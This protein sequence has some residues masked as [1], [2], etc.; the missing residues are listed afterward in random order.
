MRDLA[1][2][3]KPASSLCNLRCSYCFYETVAE[4][5]SV[6]SRG[7][8]TA[9]TAQRI[10]ANIFCDLDSGDHI[11]FAFQ[12]GEP[13]LAG[14]GFF[15][16]F[17][18]R[19]QQINPGCE[20]SY[21]LQTNGIL[22]DDSWCEFLKK[23]DF[24]VGLSL[25][26]LQPVHDGNRKDG[27]GQGTFARVMKAKEYLE[28]WQ[29]DYN[30]LATLTR[31]LAAQP[32]KVWEFIWRNKIRF[33]QFTPCFGDMPGAICPEDF[34]H[35]YGR[36]IP[37]WYNAWEKGV[38]I[39]VKLIDDLVTLLATGRITACGLTGNCA[40]QIIV[41]ADGSVYPCDFFATDSWEIG[42]LCHHSIKEIYEAPRQTQFR[43][44][45]RQ[46][47]L[48]ENCRYKA[49]CGGNCP[50]MQRHICYGKDDS[51]CGMQQLLDRQIKILLSVARQLR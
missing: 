4:N 35:F 12:G 42:N 41:E 47:P 23:Y 10:L 45:K 6:Y 38:Y 2:M 17:V 1:I 40:P 9:D 24:L 39:S 3:L 13:T 32:E 37:L 14:L 8:M 33:V 15:R 21:Q 30:V 20:I 50:V 22:L 29:I 31:E 11:S 16:E 18:L 5:R 43:G 27:A 7:I 19:V 26:C 51:A 36:L 25:D 34:A 48:C 46:L 44:R 28:R 49:I